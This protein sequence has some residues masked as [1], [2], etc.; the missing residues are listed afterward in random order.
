MFA[1]QFREGPAALSRGIFTEN[2]P[3]GERTRLATHDTTESRIARAME[4][5]ASHWTTFRVAQ[6]L[7]SRWT[8][9]SRTA[10]LQR[11]L[12]RVTPRRV[13]ADLEQAVLKSK[14]A[15]Y[16]EATPWDA[17]SLPFRSL[18]RIVE[19]LASQGTRV[20]VVLS[21]Q[22]LAF[23]EGIVDREALESNRQRLA[24]FMADRADGAVYLDWATRFPEELFLDHCH[25]TAEGN[26]RF[27][28]DL[29]SA[30]L[31]AAPG[32]VE[33]P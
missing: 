10:A 7:K 33:S 16:Y 5:L 20:I 2:L 12:E 17:S 24:R 1:P 6:L 8:L 29:A 22:N 11:A 31:G 19:R 21:P 25:L 9:P 13:D 23:L 30:V 3:P 18:G 26:V 14:V 32:E 15:S 4:G 27:A 28:R